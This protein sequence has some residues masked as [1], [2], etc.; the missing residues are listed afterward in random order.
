MLENNITENKIEKEQKA[1][2]LTNNIEGN[3]TKSIDSRI[4]KRF[5]Y[6][7]L[8]IPINKKP[9]KRNYNE[10]L[11]NSINTSKMNKNICDNNDLD[12]SE[13][14]DEFKPFKKREKNKI[15][16]KLLKQYKEIHYYY[17]NNNK[18]EWEYLEINGT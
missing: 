17:T 18:N 15:Y 10:M 8:E 13:D 6:F 9:G 14:P 11:E 1:I 5:N 2:N 12:V 3:D 16:Q 7:K 4:N